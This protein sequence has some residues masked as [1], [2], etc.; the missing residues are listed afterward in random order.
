MIVTVTL[1]PALDKTVIIPDFAV[2]QVNRITEMRLDAGGK[3][4]NV[5]KVLQV[6]QTKSVATGILGGTTGRWIESQLQEAGIRVHFAHVDKDTRTNLKVIDD[7]LHTNTDINEPGEPVGQEVLLEVYQKAPRPSDRLPGQGT[8]WC[9]PER[10][11]REPP[12]IFSKT[13][14]FPSSR[15]ASAATWMQTANC[16][17]PVWKHFP[18]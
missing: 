7:H 4:I 1:T 6:L 9:S 13:G 14:S 3:G 5:S 12:A 10:P 16:C 2:N 11:P 15:R 17:G 18:K 8:G